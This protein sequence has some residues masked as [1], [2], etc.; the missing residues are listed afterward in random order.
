MLRRAAAEYFVEGF[1]GGELRRILAQT[2]D[3]EARL[4]ARERMLPQRQAPDGY[5]VWINHLVWLER[6]LEI[7][8]V[9][10]TAAEVEGLMV[11]K[12][13]RN[14]FEAAHPACPH[15]GMPNERLTLRCRECGGEI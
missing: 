5:F 7:A 15:C 11:L 8:P 3:V 14:R 10:L 1:L 4:A 2:E 12:D 6:L 9:R 13:E